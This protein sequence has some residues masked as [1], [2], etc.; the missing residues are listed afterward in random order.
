[1]AMLVTDPTMTASGVTKVYVRYSGEEVHSSGAAGA[2]GWVNLNSSGSI[3]LESSVNST[4]T[5]ASAKVPSGAYDAAR[6][7]VSSVTVLCNGQNYTANALSS[8]LTARMETRAQV[9]ASSSVA[10]VV[11]MHTL[12]VNSGNSSRPQ[13]DFSGSAK[14]TVV[15]GNDVGTT[16]LAVGSRMDLNGQAWW[17][18]FS[19]QTTAKLHITSV[20]LT[21]G[22]VVVKVSNTGGDNTTVHAVVVTPVSMM[23]GAGMQVPAGFSGSSVITANSNST[24]QVAGQASAQAMFGGSGTDLSSGSS[25]TLAFSGTIQINVGGVISMSGVVPGQQYMVTCISGDTAVS[26]TVTAQ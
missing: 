13:F 3:E 8:Q 19:S 10:A 4:L 23:G 5:V 6:L 21:S 15:P 1:M 17:A 24:A 16:A 11:D 12:I 22:S 25:T 14:A 9:N 26:T 7:D 2:S 18:A 20:T